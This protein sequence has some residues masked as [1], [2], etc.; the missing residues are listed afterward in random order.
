MF[1]DA[2]CHLTFFKNIGEIIAEAV[3]NNVEVMVNCPNT[4]DFEQSIELAKEFKEVR[5]C[6]GL[7]PCD[8]LKMNKEEID[9]WIG[10][11]K[12]DLDKCVGLGEIGLD[13][14]Y[15]TTASQKELQEEVFVKQI[16]I[17]KEAGLPVVVH[18][19]FAERASLEVLEREQAGK[20]LMH[21][22]TNSAKLCKRVVENNWFISVGPS[23]LASEQTKKVVKG[24]SLE[25]LVL[26]TDAPVEFG[27]KEARPAWIPKVAEKVA[28]VH[29]ISIKEV[30]QQT[31]KNAKK[32]FNL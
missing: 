15:A 11:V 12:Q 20:V 26:E 9:K 23:I 31:T 8:V 10:F 2:H 27:G 4:L 22:Y 18:S 7:Y 17:A 16:S 14:K 25:N 5:T 6:L 19:R 21:W 32:I 24:I 3:K 1:V 30:E 28:E 29:N 13:H